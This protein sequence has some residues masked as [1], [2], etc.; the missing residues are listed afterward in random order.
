MVLKALLKS[1]KTAFSTFEPPSSDF[2]IVCARKPTASKVLD[3]K[4]NFL[5]SIHTPSVHLELF[6]N[7]YFVLIR[8]SFLTY[9]T[10]W[11]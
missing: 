6:L 3:D 1:T 11:T 7:V 10:Q 9:E 2:A 8:V 5:R 4:E